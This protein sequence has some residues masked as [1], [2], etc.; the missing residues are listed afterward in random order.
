MIGVDQHG[1]KRKHSTA[2]LTL[3]LQSQLARAVDN[4]SYAM[5]ASLDLSSTFDLV[6]TDLLLKRLKVFELPG[7]IIKLIGVWLKGRSYYLS[8]DGSNSIIFDLLL[9]YV[10]GSILGPVLYALYVS[11][12]FEIEDFSTYV[13]DT[14]Q[15]DLAPRLEN[16]I[17]AAF[18]ITQSNKIGF[19]VPGFI[20]Q[21]CLRQS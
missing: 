7:D 20:I 10:E 11:P 6:N 3:K 19:Q 9:G 16:V 8:I 15:Q 14:C 18:S 17:I 12:L 5:A 1:F 4:G 13:G 2:T 21:S